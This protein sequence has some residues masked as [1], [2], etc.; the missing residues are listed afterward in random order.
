M[1]VVGF[2][3]SPRKGG[4]TDTLV[5]QVLAGAA[6]AG[7]ETEKIYLADHALTPIDPVYG[8]EANWTDPR[9]GV[10]DQLIDKMVAADVVVLG[11]PVYWFSVSGL[12]KLFIDRWSLYQRGDERIGDL[13]PGKK[14][15]VALAMADSDASYIEAV[16]APLR[17]AAKWLKME[18]VGEIVATGVS[19][20]GEVGQHP[21]LLADARALG[22]SL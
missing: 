4:N 15:V 1:K 19:D 3:G 13:R 14:L 10:A 20:P 22:Q 9:Q 5:E 21:D 18:W 2:V 17:Y 7:H 6:D 16:L 8:E 11:T 12:L